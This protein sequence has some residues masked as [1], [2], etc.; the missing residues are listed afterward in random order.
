MPDIL[1][2]QPPIRDFYLTAKRTVPYGLACIAA[3]LRQAGFSVD[4]LDALATSRSRKI[5]LPPEMNYLKPFYG[6]PDVS[7][8]GLFHHYRHFGRSYAHIQQ[9]VERSGA[10]LV[11]ISSLFTAY[12]QEAVKT[13]ETV[14]AA[15]PGCKTVLGGHHPTALP[16]TVM[17]SSA[18]D[19]VLRGDGE[20]SMPLLARALANGE[21]L[22]QVPG[23]V[24]RGRNRE[25]IVS[26]SVRITDPND[27]QLPAT[28]LVDRSFYRRGKKSILAVVASR[29]C[30]MKCSY[31]SMRSSPDQ[32]YVRRSVGSVLAEIEQ[33]ADQNAALFIDFEDE[34]LSLDRRWFL[35]LLQHIQR[36][37]GG[38]TLELRAMNG[39]FPPSLDE[40][41]ICAMAEAGFTALNLSLGSAIGQQARQFQRPDVRMAFDRALALAAKYNLAAVGYVIAGAPDQKAEHSL[42][43]LLYLAAR[44]VLAGV[45]VY[46]PVPGTPDFQR[47]IDLGVLPDKTT[48]MRS[49]TF[50][51]D[52]STTREEA[53]TILR[54]ARIV[55]FM[56][57]ILD[58]GQAIPTDA[59]NPVAA[60]GDQIDRRAVG[61]H[62]LAR[63]LDDGII[64][65]VT[66][67]GRVYDHHVSTRL[68]RMFLEQLKTRGLQGT[69]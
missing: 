30:P 14:K 22:E 36:N 13:A 65:G 35:S 19:F 61:R 23:L 15:L 16:E 27:F 47:C 9:Q 24:R 37:F 3:A 58:Q 11:G 33:A 51:V 57:S 59:R 34:N 41:L 12:E 21:D 63:F 60:V 50:P 25:L 49:S 44:R 66:A 45:S 7:P 18:V 1:L 46:Y 42:E 38:T 56:K 55:N 31:C 26:E 4:I 32:P 67:S 28:E 64:R 69:L 62:L 40:E 53:V 6:L 68:T 29:G 17:Q 8:F 5:R 2:L 39:L 52:H 20:I 10:F 54:L 48:L 43:D